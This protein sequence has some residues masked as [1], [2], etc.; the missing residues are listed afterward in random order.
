MVVDIVSGA[1]TGIRVGE[2]P[3]RM[4]LSK[5]RRLYMSSTE[6]ATQCL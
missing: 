3:N 5:T 4:V 2:Q 1:F 6:T